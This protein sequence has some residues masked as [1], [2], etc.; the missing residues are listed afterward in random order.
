MK[1]NLKRWARIGLM[2]CATIGSGCVMQEGSPRYRIVREKKSAQSHP[3][4]LTEEE[5]PVVQI[6]DA[7]PPQSE[8][9]EA[10]IAAIGA[11]FSES[12]RNPPHSIGGWTP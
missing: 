12:G 4:K 11:D 3:V 9:D 5:S 10:D 1:V 8:N 6:S 7:L 2:V